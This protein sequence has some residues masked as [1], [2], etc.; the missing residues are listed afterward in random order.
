MNN[1]KPSVVAAHVDSALYGADSTRRDEVVILDKSPDL[2]ELNHLL[3]AAEIEEEAAEYQPR[4]KPVGINSPIIAI[5]T[6]YREFKDANNPSEMMNHVLCYTFTVGVDGRY[7]TGI[8]F[9]ESADKADRITIEEL[10]YQAL[11]QALDENIIRSWP[12]G[13]FV[14]AH[15]LRADFLNFKGAFDTARAKLTGIRKT[16]ASAEVYGV[17]M[18]K[19]AKKLGRHEVLTITCKSDKKREISVEFRDTM[20]IA[21]AG[22]GLKDVGESLGVPK[23]EIPAPYSITQMDVFLKEQPEQFEAYAINDA[24]ISFLHMTAFIEFCRELGLTAIPHTIG[25]LAVSAFRKHVNGN[26]NELFGSEYYQKTVWNVSQTTSSAHSKPITHRGTVP[27]TNRAM[28]EDFAIRNYHGGRNE[29]FWTGPTAVGLWYDFDL[30]SCYTAA[31]AA[32]RPIDYASARLSTNVEDYCGDFP[33]FALAEFAFPD[34]ELF[35]CLPVRTDNYGLCYPLTGQSYCTGSEIEVALSLGAKITILQGVRFDWVTGSTPIFADFMTIV[36]DNRKKYDKGSLEEKL[37]KEIGNSLYGKTAQGLVGK[38]AFDVQ[39]GISS[40]VPSSPITNPYFASHITG[41][42]RAVVSEIIARIPAHRTVVSVTTDGFLTDATLD[43]L[44]L[45]G[46][47]SQRFLE[48]LKLIDPTSESILEDKHAAA[49]ILAFKTR[50]QVSAELVDF[51]PPVTAKANVQIPRGIDDQ[52]DYMVN[53]YLNR[54]AGD[55]FKSSRLTSTR[56]QLLTECDMVNIVTDQRL[57]LE[58]DFKR[59][60]T[61]PRMIACR[62]REHIALSSR[63]HRTVNDFLRTRSAVDAWRKNGTLKTLSDWETLSDRIDIELAKDNADAKSLRIKEGETSDTLLLRVY[64]RAHMQ[65]ALGVKS[66]MSAR[67]LAESLGLEGIE[68]KASTISAAK[69]AK[70][71]LK[72]VPVNSLSIKMLVSILKIVGPFDYK[73][74]FNPKKAHLIDD[75]LAEHGVRIAPK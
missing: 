68:V 41:L 16:I 33:S 30:K 23:L 20:L 35:P 72:V 70:L 57:N 46:P 29:C 40:K 12:E 53:L 32:I 42:A 14:T 52:N 48:K 21:P 63:P 28:F 43:E 4:F 17:D 9:P 11:Q 55:T 50:G 51:L 18:D 62:G 8:I 54:E 1:F 3:L 60:L 59:E 69:K 47:L 58:P 25:S 71:V 38:T 34:D 10:I 67:L 13:V 61:E 6:E 39:K 65:R 15:F 73:E 49:Q 22:K 31:S 37:W 7:T 19:V 36:R 74:L 2:G 66:R 64:Y 45:S 56:E 27:N 44:D 5:D 75:M 26:I 24:V